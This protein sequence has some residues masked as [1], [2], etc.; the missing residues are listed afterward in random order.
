MTDYAKGYFVLFI[1]IIF[2]SMDSV[3]IRFV[4]MDWVSTAF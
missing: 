3:T 2:I 1:T 4:G